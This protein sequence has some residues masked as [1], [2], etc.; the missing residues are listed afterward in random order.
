M[1]AYL[2]KRLMT[3]QTFDEW[4]TMLLPFCAQYR[5]TAMRELQIRYLDIARIW[6]C[7]GATSFFIRRVEKPHDAILFVYS[8]GIHISLP[9]R[10]KP[11]NQWTF[12]EIAT[13]H[14]TPSSFVIRLN[15]IGDIQE[16][17]MFTRQ[18]TDIQ[19]TI[20]TYVDRLIA[21]MQAK[22]KKDMVERQRNRT[23]TRAG[24][25]VSL[26]KPPTMKRGG[27]SGINPPPLPASSSSS[28]ARPAP[29][30]PTLPPPFVVRK[31]E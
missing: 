6:P 9:G 5:G 21:D 14:A 28:P 24:P 26:L 18:G 15:A 2:P 20:K 27:G 13:W 30:P 23:N 12:Q 4:R 31:N 29:P 1:G 25:K 16:Y 10:R 19:I 8:T 3:L 11:E 22:K 17:K 7:W